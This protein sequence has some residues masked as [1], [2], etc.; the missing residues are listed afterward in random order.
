LGKIYG[1]NNVTMISKT[2]FKDVASAL[3]KMSI[4]PD[5]TKSE[6]DDVEKCQLSLNKSKQKW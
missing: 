3:I 4:T 1:F 2:K 5:C 6:V